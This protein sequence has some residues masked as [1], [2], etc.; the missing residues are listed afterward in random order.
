MNF[1]LEVTLGALFRAYR[2]QVAGLINFGQSVL[3]FL[4]EI[5]IREQ[6]DEFRAAYLRM[7]LA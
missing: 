6:A 2:R 3:N 5:P 7:S 4:P 1:L